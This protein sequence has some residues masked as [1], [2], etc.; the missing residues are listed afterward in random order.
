MASPDPIAV[1]PPGRARAIVGGFI[2]LWLVWQVALP[3]SYYFGDDAGEERF[4][5]R[6]FS[7][8]ALFHTKCAVSVAESVAVPGAADGVSVRAVDLGRT[9]HAGWEEH[10]RRNRRL[11]VERFLRWRCQRDPSVT[12]VEFRR[13]CR[14]VPESRIPSISV[15]LPCRTDALAGVPGASR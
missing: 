2:V 12:A 15:R 14:L 10:L 9:V 13:T 8:I 4:A 7:E 6:M 11:V 3:L 1:P 5:W